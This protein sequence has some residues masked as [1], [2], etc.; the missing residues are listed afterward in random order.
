MK[1]RIARATGALVVGALSL[2]IIGVLIGWFWAFVGM[3]VLAFWQVARLDR[4][5]TNGP[6]A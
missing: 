4:E 6:T 2:A 5:A 3:A 1:Q